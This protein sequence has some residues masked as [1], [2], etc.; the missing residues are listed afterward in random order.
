[1]NLEIDKKT[2]M[3]YRPD[4]MDMFVIKEKKEYQQIFNNCA[5]HTIL[6]VGANIGMFAV[7]ALKCG[8]AKVVS[9]E[10]EPD[11]FSI[12]NM[13]VKAEN[14]IAILNNVAITSEHGEMDFYVC[15]AKNK[16]RHTAIPTRGRKIIKVP[17]VPFYDEVTRYNPTIIKCDTE[18]GEYSIDWTKLPKTVE[19]LAMEIHRNKGYEEKA[20]EL[21]KWF[22]DE[23][24]ILY[25]LDTKHFGEINAHVRV[26][27]RKN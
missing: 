25:T 23:F 12:L 24:D 19:Y 10:P 27:K 8:A 16:G 17:T 13:N 18:G 6:D 5:G 7:N 2:G 4:T 11:N 15:E 26:G 20:D 1:M 9:Y 3:H 21:V 22:E 14:G